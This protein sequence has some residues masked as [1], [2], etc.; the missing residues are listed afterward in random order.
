MS[1]PT[2][3]VVLLQRAINIQHVYPQL[4]TGAVWSTVLQRLQ[5]EAPKASI[6][7]LEQT[8]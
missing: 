8:A 7:R 6:A 1:I 2:E 4:P 5:D 3:V